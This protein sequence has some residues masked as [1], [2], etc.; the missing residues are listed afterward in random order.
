MRCCSSSTGSSADPRARAGAVALALALVAASAVPARAIEPT[1]A[2]DGT[3]L[4]A[5]DVD[6][7]VRRHLE[8]VHDGGWSRFDLVEVRWANVAPPPD[9]WLGTVWGDGTPTANGSLVLYAEVHRDG[10]P[11]ERLPVAVT[12]RPWVEVPVAARALAR[13]ES[14]APADVRT[15]ERPLSELR[16]ARPI[17]PGAIDD[18]RARRDLREGELL[19]TAATEAAPLVVSGSRVTIR[20]LA[21]GLELRA[22]GVARRSGRRGDTIPV[23]NMDSRRGLSARVVDEGLVEV[24]P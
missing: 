21:P 2:A 5:A 7:A 17:D 13:G 1:S 16:G 23:T 11:L 8:R 10:A 12:V 9:A 4:R 20:Y 3:A 15:E 24:G 18:L 14:L 22:A 6:R 19:T